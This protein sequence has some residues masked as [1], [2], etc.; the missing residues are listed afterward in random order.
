[1]KKLPQRKRLRL[2][3]YDYSNR[4]YYFITICTKDKKEILSKIEYKTLTNIKPENKT[5]VVGAG[6]HT[7]L[8]REGFHTRPK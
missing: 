4:G 7:R 2:K 6:F 1:M 8:K 5:T 3:E